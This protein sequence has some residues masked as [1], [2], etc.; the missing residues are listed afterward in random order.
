[1]IFRYINCSM[2]EITFTKRRL[3]GLLLHQEDNVWRK[4][5]I[6]QKLMLRKLPIDGAL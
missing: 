3:E 4:A 6:I 5:K 2:N 1:M